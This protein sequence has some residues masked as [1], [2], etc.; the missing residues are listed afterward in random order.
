M[1]IRWISESSWAKKPFRF[2]SKYGN[3]EENSAIPSDNNM[4][5][6]PTQVHAKIQ[7]AVPEWSVS[8]LVEKP[9]LG[10]HFDIFRGDFA[11]FCRSNSDKL[12][13][14]ILE[15]LSKRTPIDQARLGKILLVVNRPRAKGV[16]LKI[17][18]QDTP[19]SDAAGAVFKIIYFNFVWEDFDPDQFIPA[20]MRH[21]YPLTNW[22]GEN[23]ATSILLNLKSP[24]VDEAVRTLL[25]FEHLDLSAV[26]FLANRGDSAVWP[27]LRRQIESDVQRRFDFWTT[28]SWLSPALNI[29]EKAEPS[30]Q[31][32]IVVTAKTQLLMMI[33]NNYRDWPERAVALIQLHQAASITHDLEFLEN[34]AAS[35]LDSRI[36]HAAKLALL[37][38]KITD[39]LPSIQSLSDERDQLHNLG[40]E[41][42]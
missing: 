19:K 41:G 23:S 22:W 5:L 25:E 26:D 11:E 8:T 30:L 9:E 16:F 14:C 37:D 36:R 42:A 15:E 31:S 28:T 17:L 32:Q 34:I 20:I 33:K 1:F 39:H 6:Y 18:E 27:A 35:N 21:L 2:R 40:W 4:P 13:T 7:L 12:Q 3:R 24:D 38:E 29:V 10:D